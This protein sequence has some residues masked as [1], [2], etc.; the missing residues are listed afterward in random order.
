MLKFNKSMRNLKLNLEDQLIIIDFFS[1]D[2]LCNIYLFN[3]ASYC[4]VVLLW[5][6]FVVCCCFVVVLLLF[7]VAVLLLSFV[8]Y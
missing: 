8:F 2:I 5:F 3:G 1:S 7:V 4:V 6:V